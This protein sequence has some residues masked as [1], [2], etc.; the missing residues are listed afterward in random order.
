MRIL[1]IALLASSRPKFCAEHEY[2]GFRG[3]TC[4]LIGTRCERSQKRRRSANKNEEHNRKNS[5]T[6][7]HPKL[8]TLSLRNRKIQQATHLCCA[9]P[10]VDITTKSSCV[11]FQ[12]YETNVFEH[13]KS[14]AFEC[15]G[16]F[17]DFFL[18]LLHNEATSR[19]KSRKSRFLR[20]RATQ[21]HFSAKRKASPANFSF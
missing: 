21:M 7:K 10:T 11:G 12:N 15:S 8:C 5:F 20:Y 19:P 17:F 1:K 3:L 14:S 6:N 13:P 9:A 2:D 4:M 16:R 18:C